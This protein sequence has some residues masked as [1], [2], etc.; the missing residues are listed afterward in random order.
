MKL[1]ENQKKVFAL[2]KTH[3][4]RAQHILA[5]LR[6]PDGGDE[7]DKG[8]YTAPIRLWF[9]G[10]EYP[11][12]GFSPLYRHEV[13]AL[14]TPAEVLALWEAAQGCSH[15]VGDWH[16]FAHISMALRAIWYLMTPESEW[17]TAP[18]WPEEA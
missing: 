17:G 10:E 16:Y 13:A 12:F 6:G 9:Y 8:E 7:D 5:A 18:W 2:F 11:T 3:P 1:T 4:R 14:K 15:N